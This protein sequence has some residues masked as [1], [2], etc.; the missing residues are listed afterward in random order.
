VRLIDHVGRQRLKIVRAQQP[1]GS[2]SVEGDVQEGLEPGI[3]QPQPGT[4]GIYRFADF[5]R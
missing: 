5:R 3:R 2:G 4:P 1:E